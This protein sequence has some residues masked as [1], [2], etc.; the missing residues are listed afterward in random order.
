M[1]MILENLPKEIINRIMIFNSHP[2]ADVFKKS[3]CYN[4]FRTMHSDEDFSD[5]WSEVYRP[6]NG[7]F[8]LGVKGR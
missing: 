8:K 4:M 1:K 2:L 6:M 3:E 7:C 5:Y